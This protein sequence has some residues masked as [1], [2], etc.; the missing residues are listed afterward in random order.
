MAEMLDVRTSVDDMVRRSAVC[1]NRPC[2]R[3]TIKTLVAFDN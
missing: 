2:S 3:H 1:H